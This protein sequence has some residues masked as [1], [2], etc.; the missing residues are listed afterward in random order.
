ML[1]AVKQQQHVLSLQ[2]LLQISS[3]L[4]IFHFFE[5]K[6]LSNNQRNMFGIA[7]SIQFDLADPVPEFA[8]E[9]SRYFLSKA[10]LTRT[11]IPMQDDQAHLAAQALFYLFQ[12]CFPSDEWC[13]WSKKIVEVFLV[14]RSLFRP[15]FLCLCRC[16]DT[17][18]DI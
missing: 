4:A 13:Q 10:R 16:P 9:I 11:A 15:T 17:L 5:P 2:V 7:D 8:S 14:C 6:R 3:N 1:K 12:Y 18:G